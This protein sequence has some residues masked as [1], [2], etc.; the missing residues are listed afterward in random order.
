MR[1][2]FSPVLRVAEIKAL[3]WRD[4]DLQADSSTL[5]PRFQKPARA[6][7]VPILDNLRAWLQPIAK[8]SGPVVG[9]NLRKRHEAARSAQE[10]GNGRTTA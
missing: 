1:S 9:P 2:D 5:A 7:L 8:T 10:S 6:D 3:D 4:V